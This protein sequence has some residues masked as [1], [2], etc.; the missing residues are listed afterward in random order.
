MHIGL[1]VPDL[2]RG[3]GWGRYSLEL[4]RALQRR[5]IRLTIISAR[6]SPTQTDITLRA[7]LP[8]VTPPDRFSML[9][10]LAALPQ[11]RTALRDCDI[12]HSAIEPYAPLAAA[13]AGPRPL[14]ITGHGSYVH[15]PEIR[16]WP[17]NRVYAMSFRRST[18]I[19][20]SQYTADVASKVTPGIRTV[21]INNGVDAGRYAELPPL[22]NRPAGPIILSA[23]GV[24]ARKG[25][26]ELVHAFARV[27]QKLPDAQ[28]VVLGSDKAEPD[29]TRQVHEAAQ[30]LEL[31][32]SLQIKGFV[33]DEE[34]LAWYGAADVF[35]MPSNKDG[36]KFEGFGLVYLEAGAAELPVIGKSQSGAQDA[37]ADGE[38]GF[39]IDAER[40]DEELPQAILRILKNPDMKHRMGKAGRQRAL[41]MSWDRCAEQTV[42]AYEA[43]LR[44][45]DG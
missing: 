17:L 11:V 14:F 22:T 30:M 12:I 2:N 3:N 4:I 32:D 5:E 8:T 15:L 44:K 20:V 24:K 45:K 33:S 38:T 21:V 18:L 6:N 34:V 19:C 1:L 40:T 16:R 35:V 29:Y 41:A 26:L 7:I 42:T 23:G 10:M 28:C 9:Q 13:V 43:S 39:L 31:G 27:R 25:T 37:I 36:W